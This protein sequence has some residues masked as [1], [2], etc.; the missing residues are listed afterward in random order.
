MTGWFLEWTVS[1]RNVGRSP[2][3]FQH[4]R[5]QLHFD[6]MDQTLYERYGIAKVTQVIT[7]FYASVLDSPRLSRYFDGVHMQTLVEHQSAFMV[8]A[9]GGPDTFTEEHLREVHA[10]LKIT[11]EDFSEMMSLLRMTLDDSGFDPAD[12]EAVLNRYEQT[13]EL[14]VPAAS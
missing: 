6:S 9:M 2:Y 4:G 10:G 3:H 12:A 1:E 14:I 7:R 8:T 11:D 13:R 5:G